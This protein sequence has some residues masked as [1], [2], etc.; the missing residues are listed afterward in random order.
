METTTCQWEFGESLDQV[1][2]IVETPLIVAG[3]GKSSYY[4]AG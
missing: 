2:V 1:A 3:L 4:I